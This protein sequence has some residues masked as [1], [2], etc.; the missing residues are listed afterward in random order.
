MNIPDDPMNLYRDRPE[1]QSVRGHLTGRTSLGQHAELIFEVGMPDNAEA[2]EAGAEKLAHIVW[3]TLAG[4]QEPETMD[5]T[6]EGEPDANLIKAT[7][8]AMERQ[9]KAI[10][11]FNAFMT[12]VHETKP[13][14][15]QPK[16]N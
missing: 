11:A 6:I 10:Q 9:A 7:A 4:A 8:E 3:H 15:F 14:D 12:K 13:K 5:I 1:G 16:W 2:H